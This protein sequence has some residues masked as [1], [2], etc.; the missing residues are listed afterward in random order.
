M[1]QALRDLLSRKPL[2]RAEI[3]AFLEEQMFPL[4]EGR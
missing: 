4:V 1:N 2:E 3:D